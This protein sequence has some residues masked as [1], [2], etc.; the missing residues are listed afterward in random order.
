MGAIVEIENFNFAIGGGNRFQVVI[1][2]QLPAKEQE[3]IPVFG[4]VLI[5]GHISSTWVVFEFFRVFD[6]MKFKINRL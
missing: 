4:Q 2:A 5:D 3:S 1:S 6:E